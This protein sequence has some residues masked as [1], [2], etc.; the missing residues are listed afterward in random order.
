[1][2]KASD[3]PLMAPHTPN[4]PVMVLL[5][6]SLRS[7][8]WNTSCAQALGTPAAVAAMRLFLHQSHFLPHRP[9]FTHFYKNVLI[10]P[11]NLLY[12]KEKF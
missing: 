9:M 5:L 7:T 12:V 8:F 10:M 3:D 6:K 4:F 2:E 11:D 1:M